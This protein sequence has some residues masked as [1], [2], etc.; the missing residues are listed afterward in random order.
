MDEWLEYIFPGA[1]AVEDEVH[2]IIRTIRDNQ[3]LETRSSLSASPSLKDN[4]AFVISSRRMA[5]Q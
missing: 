2:L 3:A 1:M 5:L 4:Q